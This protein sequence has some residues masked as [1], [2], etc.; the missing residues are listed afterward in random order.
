M[1][2]HRV[3]F[4]V[5]NLMA[6]TAVVALLVLWAEGVFCSL[7]PAPVFRP[8]HPL[9]FMPPGDHPCRG[10]ASGD[11]R[12]AC[13]ADRKRRANSIAV[14]PR[15]LGFRLQ[16]P[17]GIVDGR[18]RMIDGKGM[19]IPPGGAADIVIEWRTGK[20][21]GPFSNYAILGTSD[22]RFPEIRLAVEGSVQPT[23]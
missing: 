21:P 1:R 13:V 8:T 14:L 7:P 17:C 11:Y 16:A 5:R 6:S 18:E 15:L 10:D 12:A 19:M 22:P 20:L 9:N 23:R 4:S 2:L 3:R